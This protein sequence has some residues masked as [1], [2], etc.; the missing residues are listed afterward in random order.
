MHDEDRT[1]R[2]ASAQEADRTQAS[3]LHHAVAAAKAEPPAELTVT[4]MIEQFGG[5][6][7][8]QSEAIERAVSALVADGLLRRSGDLIRPSRAALRFEHFDSNF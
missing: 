3:I 6:A 7:D 2:R 5:D 4:A 1:G 8:E